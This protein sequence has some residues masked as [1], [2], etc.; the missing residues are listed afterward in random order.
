MLQNRQTPN[1]PSKRILRSSKC[2]TNSD[3]LERRRSGV[4]INEIRD[5]ETRHDRRARF[6]QG[7]VRRARK[8]AKDSNLG[9]TLRDFSLS[10]PPSFPL[11]LSLSLSLSLFP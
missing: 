8:P 5:I 1:I 6:E 2:C 9:V 11:S 10:A 4:D 3:Q 7:A